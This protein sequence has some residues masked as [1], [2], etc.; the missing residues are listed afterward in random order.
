MNSKHI[1]LLFAAFL[2][3]I[4]LF[5]CGDLI[6][7]FE[8]EEYSMSEQDQQGVE[9]L[10]DTLFV[11]RES[12]VMRKWDYRYNQNYSIDT[13]LTNYFEVVYDTTSDTSGSDTSGTTIDTL[14]RFAFTG[15][16]NVKDTIHF[17]LSTGDNITLYFDTSFTVIDTVRAQE[18]SAQYTATVPLQRTYSLDYYLIRFT[19]SERDTLPLSDIS[20]ILDSLEA[21]S[22]FVRSIDSL[23]SL[24]AASGS[25][26]FSLK[27]SAAGEETVFLLKDFVSISITTESGDTLEPKSTVIPP[28]VSAAYYVLLNPQGQIAEEGDEIDKI[29][30][31]IKTRHVYNLMNNKRYL[32]NISTTEQTILKNSA[33]QLAIVS[34]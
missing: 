1:K 5:K 27:L 17:D 2:L 9:L 4:L 26:H 30:P 6:S 10:K 14:Y 20:T 33:F 13:T 11:S 32:V 31:V 24:K 23:I 18:Q 8:E 19:T 28:E 25:N 3:P 15:D 22:A 34:M 12:A 16:F 7:D 29:E 21:D